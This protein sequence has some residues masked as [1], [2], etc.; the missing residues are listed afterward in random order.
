MSGA[1]EV[2]GVQPRAAGASGPT[3]RETSPLPA[4]VASAAAPEYG[5][6][7]QP[8]V[9]VPV[10]EAPLTPAAKGTLRALLDTERARSIIVPLLPHGV[11]YEEV[12]A[13]TAHAVANNPELLQCTPMSLIYAI[14]R[15]VQTGLVIGEKVHIVPYNVK[16]SKK[17]EPD[18]YEKRAQKITDYK[19]EL[20]LVMH[21]GCVKAVK[22]QCVYENEIAQKHGGM[23]EYLEGS[24]TEI[25]HRR[26]YDPD[27]RGRLV[28]AYAAAYTAIGIPPTVV[29]LHIKEIEQIRAK[30][31][32]WSGLSVCPPWYAK[33]TA[34]HA[35]AK[36]L[37]MSRR[38]AMIFRHIEVEETDD[39]DDGFGE[40]LAV[41]EAPAA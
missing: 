19:G 26:I 5:A 10:R 20:E 16:V 3:L 37:P 25:L 11:K 38:V 6:V 22:T 29:Y 21:A 4:P 7:L 23:F 8:T 1:S 17:G 9:S 24:S 12:Y 35:L 31:K 32:S 36:L 30:S 39:I 27:E 33:K 2:Q 40:P 28:G 14:G 34:V 13:E 41:V 18:R 15:A